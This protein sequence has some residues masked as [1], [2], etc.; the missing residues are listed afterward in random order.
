MEWR[1]RSVAPESRGRI[2]KTD[3]ERPPVQA[4]YWVTGSA[5]GLLKSQTMFYVCSPCDPTCRPT[6]TRPWPG[7]R[8]SRSASAATTASGGMTCAWLPLRR[9][10]GTASRWGHWSGNGRP[11]ARGTTR[12]RPGNPRNT[13][14][15]AVGI[16]RTSASTRRPTCRRQ[17]AAWSSSKGVRR[18]C[19]QRSRLASDVGGSAP[20]TKARTRPS[21]RR[22]YRP[23]P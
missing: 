12:I 17:W 3:T 18:T 16:A 11:Y 21:R 4:L 22:G 5:R 8:G 7:G 2:R 23:T 15:N 14:P 9:R 1:T 10:R 6:K 19:Y 13:G 20:R